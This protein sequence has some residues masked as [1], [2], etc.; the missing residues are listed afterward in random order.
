M[1]APPEANAV[2][3]GGQSGFYLPAEAV[4]KGSSA[5]AERKTRGRPP[6]GDGRTIESVC[7]VIRPA[8]NLFGL[9]ATLSSVKP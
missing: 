3:V 7:G 6:P 8:E 1:A 4:V 2:V 5:E 9:L